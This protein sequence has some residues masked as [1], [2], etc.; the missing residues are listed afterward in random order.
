MYM[1]FFD[2]PQEF[3]RKICLSHEVE[4][5]FCIG[6]AQMEEDILDAA[7]QCKDLGGSLCG[8]ESAAPKKLKEIKA[9]SLI[10]LALK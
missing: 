7:R 2:F 3:G 8:G 1:R 4:S 6:S 10:K 9:K 5:Q